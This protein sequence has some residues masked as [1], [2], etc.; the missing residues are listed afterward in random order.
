[1]MIHETPAAR[2][3][4]QAAE[5]AAFWARLAEQRRARDRLCGCPL[6]SLGSVYLNSIY[7]RICSRPV[8]AAPDPEEE[9][10]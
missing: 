8:R 7:C 4:R 3:A 10:A 9:T 6:P 5:Q 2:R 1:M